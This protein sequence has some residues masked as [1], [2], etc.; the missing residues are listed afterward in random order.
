MVV[1]FLFLGNMSLLYIGVWT[2]LTVLQRLSSC[3]SVGM[4]AVIF[5]I[6]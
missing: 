1:A 3:P 4:N 6:W 2:V 5:I